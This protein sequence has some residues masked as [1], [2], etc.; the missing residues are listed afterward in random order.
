MAVEDRDI[1]ILTDFQRA[2]SLVNSQFA[3]G[4]DRDHLQG[5]LHR[6]VAVLE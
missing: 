1:A 5:T 6:H 4:V 2:D 3:G